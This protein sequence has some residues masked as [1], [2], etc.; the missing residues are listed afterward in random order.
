MSLARPENVDV[1]VIGAGVSGL[2]ACEALL[3]HGFDVVTLESRERIGGRLCSAATGGGRLD[4][5]ATWFWPGERRVEELVSRLSIATHEQYL[6]GDAVYHDPAGSHRMNGNP[7]DVASFRFSDG[8][9]GL[10]R[11]LA[12]NVPEERIRLDDAATSVQSSGDKMLVSSQRSSLEA[13]HVV[14]ALPPALAVSCI[15]FAGELEDRVLGLA[16]LTPVWMG[17]TAKVVVGY[18]EPFWRSVGLSGSGVSHFGP[19]REIHDMSGPN[20]QPAS[21]FGFGQTGAHGVAELSEASVIEQLV[22][23]FGAVAGRPETVIIQDWKAEPWTSPY[24]VERLDAYQTY[25]HDLYQRAALGGR[26]HW[27]ST[28]TSVINPGHIEGALA[29]AERAVRA[30]VDDLQ[31]DQMGT[32]S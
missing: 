16:A 18:A 5:G 6:D 8:A 26:L 21:L 22:S 31:P 1:V 19:L 15:D 11:G 28:E 17:S 14:L 10:V 30:I 32:T 27:S 4:L 7:L 13:S 20:G 12:N 3:A 24:G 9:D 23:M 2:V 25:G 29:A